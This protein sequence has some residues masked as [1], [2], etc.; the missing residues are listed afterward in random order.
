M[1]NIVPYTD[2]FSVNETHCQQPN[3]ASISAV[4]D[5]LKNEI[6]GLYQM[7]WLTQLTESDDPY[8]I[9]WLTHKV[10]DSN[11]PYGH[12]KKQLSHHYPFTGI[13][14]DMMYQQ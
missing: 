8:H 11:N 10:S 12:H 3:D 4:A 1:I 5:K 9:F 13:L 14:Y 2:H 6:D 7:Y